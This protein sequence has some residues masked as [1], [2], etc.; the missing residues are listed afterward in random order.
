ME[1]FLVQTTRLLIAMFAIYGKK[2][3]ERPVVLAL[4]G[5]RSFK[6]MLNRAPS[7][8]L[9]RQS[10]LQQTTNFAISFPI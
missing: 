8:T 10:Q 2:T 7:L 5:H 6:M 1:T 3:L 9:K 4:Q